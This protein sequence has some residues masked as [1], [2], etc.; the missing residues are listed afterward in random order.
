M[1]VSGKTKSVGPQ[2]HMY[3]F[4]PS[5]HGMQELF[6]GAF[7]EIANG[8]LGDAILEVRVDATVGD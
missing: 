4:W 7:L 8:F 6:P 3:S 1:E 5:R 2:S